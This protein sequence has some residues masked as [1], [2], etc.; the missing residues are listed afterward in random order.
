MQ[1]GNFKYVRNNSGRWIYFFKFNSMKS[2]YRSHASDENL[3]SELKCALS[4]KHTPD[5]E[6]LAWK[7]QPY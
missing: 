2:K 3:V 6:H 7:K 5:S 1:L 4:G